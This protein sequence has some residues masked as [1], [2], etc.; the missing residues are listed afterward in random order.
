MTGQDG[1]LPS[2][3]HNNVVKT[4]QGSM[5]WTGFVWDISGMLLGASS[6]RTD[7]RLD[8]P[9]LR[10]VPAAASFQRAKSTFFVRNLLRL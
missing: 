5:K 4:V 7:A 10:A 1:N 9:A 2:A 3:S 8:C 6:R